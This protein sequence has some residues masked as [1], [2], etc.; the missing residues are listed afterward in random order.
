MSKDYAKSTNLQLRNTG[1]RGLLPFQILLDLSLCANAIRFYGVIEQLESRPGGKEVYFTNAYIAGILGI[2]IR[3]TQKIGAQ[4]REKG[5]I[6]REQISANSWRWGTCKNPPI[7][8]ETTPLRLA[9]C[10]C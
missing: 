4:L 8:E 10:K 2:T 3:Q 9:K 7:E 1:Y 6:T 5:Y